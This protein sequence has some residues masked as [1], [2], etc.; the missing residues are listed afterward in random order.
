MELKVVVG[1]Q[2]WGNGRAPS[3][4]TH[5]QGAPL[6]GQWGG[7]EVNMRGDST[8]RRDRARWEGK[9]GPWS[10]CHLDGVCKKRDS[11]QQQ[12]TEPPPGAVSSTL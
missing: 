3:P 12:A 1:V 2:P 6:L 9:H 8:E 11:C 7:S 10:Q 5:R 4:G